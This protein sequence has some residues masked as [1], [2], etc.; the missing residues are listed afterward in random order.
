MQHRAEV[1]QVAWDAGQVLQVG[2]NGQEGDGGV[3]VEGLLVG[4]EPGIVVNQR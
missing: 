4:G 2:G 3:P 1:G